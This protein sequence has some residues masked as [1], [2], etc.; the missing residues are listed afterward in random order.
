MAYFFCWLFS[1][2][3]AAADPFPVV[4]VPGF[5]SS[6]LEMNLT[7]E[8]DPESH[9]CLWQKNGYWFRTW[10]NLDMLVPPFADCTMQRV[11]TVWDLQTGNIANW[12]GVDV[13]VPD[14]GGTGGIET[15]DPDHS[16]P[17]RLGAVFGPLIDKLL[18]LGYEKNLT[19]RGAPYDWRY[20]PTS[21]FGAKYV[22]DLK[23]LVEE[24]ARAQGSKVMLLS[25][26]LGGLFTLHLLRNVSQE[27]KD[28]YVRGW[29][30]VGT[31]FAGSVTSLQMV[32]AGNNENIFSLPNKRFKETQRTW[33]TA[34]WMLPDERLFGDSLM[35]STPTKNYTGNDFAQLFEAVGFEDGFEFFQRRRELLKDP[36]TPVGVPTYCFLSK[37]TKQLERM[38]Y[39]SN[40]TDKYPSLIS[41]TNGDGSVQYPSLRICKDIKP[42]K[43]FE[44]ENIEHLAMIQDKRSVD[45]IVDL[46]RSLQDGIE[47]VV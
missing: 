28:T 39:T 2:A 31:P 19:L 34:W 18:P 37:G 17:A 24:T 25:H 4:L 1:L 6:V 38:V 29:I 21:D 14:W 11:K 47:V 41:D 40:D 44:F 46:V 16:I 32:I 7:E 23:L 35:V 9:W 27:W 43:V 3:V 15:L 42:D 45:A 20:A 12:P 22:T 30:S 36:W 13:R 33:E 5:A 8:Y 10:V 26:S